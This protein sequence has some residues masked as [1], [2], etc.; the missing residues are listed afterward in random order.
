MIKTDTARSPLLKPVIERKYT[1]GLTIDDKGSASMPGADKEVKETT[2]GSQAGQTAAG[3]GSPG[4]G[5]APGPGTKFNIP[6]SD[7]TKGFSF[8]D[9]PE[10]GE[11]EDTGKAAD[12]GISSMSAKSFANF[13]SNAIAVYVPRVSYKICSVDISDVRLEIE[14]TN[15]TPNWL[16]FFE[17]VNERTAEGVK[18]PQDSLKMWEK[19]CQAYLE[20]KKFNFANPETAFWA[21]TIALAG[22]ISVNII[23]LKATNKDL[24]RQALAS[25]RPDL[26]IKPPTEPQKTEKDGEHK[27]A[28]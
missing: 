8:D 26:Y 28:A 27:Q 9:F 20:Y 19:A 3:P 24:M 1:Q 25:S 15:L 13:A 10:R 2:T 22:E 23:Q 6:P 7:D 17:G 16:P 14:K 21:A 11:I 12:I 18:V 5:A 4:T